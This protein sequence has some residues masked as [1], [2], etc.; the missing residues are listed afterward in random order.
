MS[1]LVYVIAIFLPKMASLTANTIRLFSIEVVMKLL[2]SYRTC[3]IIQ[4][5]IP[6][7]SFIWL[8]FYHEMDVSW[9]EGGVINS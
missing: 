9:L 5:K 1:T 6:L 4:L 2:L 8:H 3:L 7:H